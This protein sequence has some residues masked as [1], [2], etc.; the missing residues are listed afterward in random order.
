MRRKEAGRG[1]RTPTEMCCRMF[2]EQVSRF[3]NCQK[4]D[5]T[6]IAIGLGR[7]RDT[8]R[9]TDNVGMSNQMTALRLPIGEMPFDVHLRPP[10]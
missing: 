10:F 4:I 6:N 7:E 1:V 3:K 5:K 8:D 9:Q 2:W